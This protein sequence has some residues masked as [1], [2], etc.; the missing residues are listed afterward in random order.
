MKR[1]LLFLSLLLSVTALAQAMASYPGDR[2][3]RVATTSSPNCGVL[4]NSAVLY[5]DS[6]A[7]GAC[8]STSPTA[9]LATLLPGWSLSINVGDGPAAV[10]GYTAAQIRTRYEAT[11]DA[12]CAGERCGCYLFEGGVNSLKGGTSVA[13]TL[14]DML[15]MVDDAVAL[16]RCV[17]V[18][19]V[20]PYAS[21]TEPTCSAGQVVDAHEK[22][23][24][25]NGALAAACATRPTIR[26]VL[27]YTTF[28]REEDPP[29]HLATAYACGNGDG[30]HLQ[31]AGTDELA[32]QVAEAV[33]EAKAAV[34]L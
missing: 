7:A 28:E 8:S 1:A 19:G 15:A 29:G 31:Q 9:T 33:A 21:C 16:G 17:V 20:L 34:C 22:A 6:I 24:A 23:T 13:A 26:C 4:P 18:V 5:G 12:A 3:G 25:Y 2:P 27:P 11:R 10:S 32:A 14:E 30:I